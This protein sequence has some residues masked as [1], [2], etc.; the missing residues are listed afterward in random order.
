MVLIIHQSKSK[1]RAISD[2]FYHMGIV[3]YAATPKEA[4]AEISSLYR[5][6][7]F[8]DPERL[9]DT[10]SLVNKLRSY[11]TR[12]PLLA[13]LNA[14]EADISAGFDVVYQSDVYSSRLVNE[15]MKYQTS[16][17]L[18]LTSQ[19]TLSGIEAS[20]ERNS[21]SVFDK[22]MNLTKTETMILRYLIASYPAPKNAGSILKYAFK[23]L[24]RP[25]EASIRTHVSVI[26]RKMREAHGSNLICSVAGKGYIVSTPE[27]L[28][29]ENAP[30]PVKV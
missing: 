12:V 3:S 8:L 4:L 23:P 13:V 20:C 24:R 27:M 25:E 1:A 6:V 30:E 5:A 14:G 10:E 9:T 15:I 16:H 26:N 21:V 28:R 29:T 17:G 11:N 2:M 22:P 7:L 18:P 19:Y